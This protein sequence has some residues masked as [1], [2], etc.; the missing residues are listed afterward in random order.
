[1]ATAREMVSPNIVDGLVVA[2]GTNTALDFVARY[3]DYADVL[4]APRMLH[5]I[6]GVQ[7]VASVLNR[8]GVTIRNGAVVLSLDLWTL[9]LSG[10]GAG[11][12]T[13]VG[14]AAKVLEAVGMADLRISARWGSAPALFQHFSDNPCGLDVWS[15]MG[16]RLKMLNQTGFE[17]AKEWLTDR[18]DNFEIPA[19]MRYR[20]TGKK[21]DTPR[22]EFL[23]APR[24]NILA[25]SAE[26]WFFNNVLESDSMGG[27]L[28]RW[29]PVRIESR[30]RDIAVPRLPDP[31][32][33]DPLAEKLRQI[34][35]LSG[36]AD[37]SA[38][39]SS[40]E[41]WYTDTKTRF[42]K[43]PNTALSDAYFNRHRNHVLKLAVIFE[44][45]ECGTLRVSQRAWKRAVEFMH[46]VEQSIFRL[47]PTGMSA[48]G[49][50]VQR[51]EEKIKQAAKR[52]ISK[53]EFTRAFQS[54]KPRDRDEGVKTLLETGRIRIEE[55]HSAARG[56]RTKII[57][58]HE[59]YAS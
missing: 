56:G 29:I 11:R 9:L 39:R 54:M 1:M 24:I 45:S 47:L 5:E 31:A 33:L 30:R 21:S 28:P 4:E 15:E 7:L 6:V 25:T 36:E 19:P 23:R 55:A 50:L 38:I 2:P 49:F 57:Y 10:S 14:M 34:A 22:I 46:R 12:S 26:A 16:E 42:L 44:V 43:H 35:S 13:T 58:L 3:A 27:F 17:T 48:Q 59:D 40:Y 32:S 53:N 52:G 37:L 8:G 20:E 41:Q 51:M 18:Y